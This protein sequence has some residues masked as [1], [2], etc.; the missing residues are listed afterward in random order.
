MNYQ[1][2]VVR[3]KLILFLSFFFLL[4][5]A[6][7]YF[8]GWQEIPPGSD[9]V[10]YNGYALAILN[11]SGWLS[12]PDFLGNYRPPA[13]PIFLAIIYSIFGAENLYAVY[14]FQAVLSTLVVYY[15]FRLSASIFNEKESYLALFW[16]GVYA[17]YF[18]Y[19]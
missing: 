17:F 11:Q 1:S 13:Y 10:G 9:G 8:F 16:A 2:L 6:Y 12:D 3:N 15:I 18:W 5:I 4:R 14:F 19:A 7:S